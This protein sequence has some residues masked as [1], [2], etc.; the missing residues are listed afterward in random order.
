MQQ[1]GVILMEEHNHELSIHIPP[2]KNSKSL[3]TKQS[4]KIS[5]TIFEGPLNEKCGECVKAEINA[6]LSKTRSMSR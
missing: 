4:H 3:R 6:F 1:V 2:K 5:Y